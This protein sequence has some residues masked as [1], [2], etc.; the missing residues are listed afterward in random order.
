M[1]TLVLGVSRMQGIG[2]ASKAPYDMARVLVMQPI[3]PF[4][5]E[6]LSITGYG[7]E[8]AEVSLKAEAIEQF[9]GLKFPVQLDLDT[10]METRG[11]KVQLIVTGIVKKAA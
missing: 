1:Q 8:M 7:Y 9:A 5:K 6:G 3:R 10:D 2:K 11:G 4:S